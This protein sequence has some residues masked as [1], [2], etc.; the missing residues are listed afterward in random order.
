MTPTFVHLHVHSDYSLVDST[1]RLPDKPEYGDPAKA[2]SRPNLISRAVESN[3]PA[4]ALTDQC[5]LFALVKFYRAAEANG[6]KPIAGADVYLPNPNDT[7]RPFRLTLLCLNHTGY[8]NLARLV[9]RCYLEGRQGDFVIAQPEWFDGCSEG[10]IALA[11]RQSDVGQLLLADKFDAAR[12]ATR[13]WLRYFDDRWYF[14]LTRTGHADE[15]HFIDTAIRL[16]GELHLPCVATNDVRF[17]TREDFESHE[18][19]VC[20]RQGRLLSDPKRPRDYTAEQYLKTAEEM[21]ELF[22]DL[23]QALEN[24]VEIAKRCN[25]EMSFGK[26]YLPDFPVPAGE[27]IETFIRKQAHAGLEA[28]LTKHGVAANFTREDY[29]ARLDRD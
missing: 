23:P 20:I 25:L 14:E 15:P 11:G 5:N 17:L 26:Y 22:A 16:A 28:R 29:V 27:T 4:L 6:I 8:L 1:I 24:S 9:S 12:D 10:L 2:G 13:E 19:R 18:A 21:A 3:Q 7:H